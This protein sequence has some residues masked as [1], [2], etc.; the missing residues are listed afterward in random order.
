MTTQTIVPTIV[1]STYRDGTIITEYAGKLVSA[2]VA[3]ALAQPTNTNVKF[4]IS[5]LRDV[6]HVSNTTGGPITV[7]VTP[8]TTVGDCDMG[9]THNFVQTIAA[10]TGYK[11]FTIPYADKYTDSDGYVTMVFS[12]VATGVTAGIFRMPV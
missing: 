4:L 12:S 10:T 8:I 9:G 1:G 11:M 2:G 7:T 3:Y 6:I 5:P